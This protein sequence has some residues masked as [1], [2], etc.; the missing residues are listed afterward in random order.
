MLP[1][2]HRITYQE[3]DR[4]L[5]RLTTGPHIRRIVFAL[6]Q[7]HNMI[8]VDHV[9]LQQINQT[10]SLSTLLKNTGQYDQTPILVDLPY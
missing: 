1:S 9:V 6:E 7:T 3:T 10:F 4:S 5:S 8:W 2:T